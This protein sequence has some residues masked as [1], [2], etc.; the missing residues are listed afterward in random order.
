MI[1]FDGGQIGTLGQNQGV[2]PV[3]TVPEGVTIVQS[4][5]LPVVGTSRW[6]LIFDIDAPGVETADIRAYLAKDGQPLTE[7]WLGQVHPAVLKGAA[8]E[9]AGLG[10]PKALEEVLEQAGVSL[11]VAVVLGD[12]EVGRAFA[13]LPVRELLQHPASTIYR[14]PPESTP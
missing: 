3:V 12:V 4:Y 9:L 7:T 14:N 11:K 13:R 6:R 2:E 5:A 1:D 10:R 8:G